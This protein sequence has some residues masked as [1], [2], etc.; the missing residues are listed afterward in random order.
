MS[1]AFNF[2]E[3]VAEGRLLLAFILVSSSVVTSV[4]GVKTIHKVEIFP[5]ITFF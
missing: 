5:E 3:M 4:V 1:R 2:R